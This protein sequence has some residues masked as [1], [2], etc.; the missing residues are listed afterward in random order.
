MVGSCKHWKD[1]DQDSAYGSG[2]E[3]MVRIQAEPDQRKWCGSRRIRIRGNGAD[4]D[5]NQQLQ[6]K[7]PIQ[8][9]EVYVAFINDFQAEV[10]VPPPYR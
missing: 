10:L 5:L 6:T 7:K 4:L 8:C 3:E 2:S 1:P 9:I